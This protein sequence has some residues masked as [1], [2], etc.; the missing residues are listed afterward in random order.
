[1]KML[2]RITGSKDLSEGIKN[3]L[4]RNAFNDKVVFRIHVHPEMVFL[5]NFCVMLKK[6]IL[7]IST[8]CLLAP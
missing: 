8:I 1:M 4:E 3:T 5:P 2:I 6:I 7:G